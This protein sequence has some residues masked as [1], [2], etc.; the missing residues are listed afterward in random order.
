MFLV[1]LSLLVGCKALDPD[2]T[3]Y[4]FSDCDQMQG[5]MEKMARKEVLWDYH[6]D[7]EGLVMGGM[8]QTDY[9][10]SDVQSEE[11]SA[12]SSYSTTNVQEQGVD[13]ADLVKTDGQYLYSVADDNLVISQAWPVEEVRLLSMTAID[14]RVDGIYLLGDR[15]AVLSRI[16]GTPRPRSGG[17]L[18][19]SL[20]SG[21]TLVT[22]VDVTD[23]SSPVVLRET[24]AE[25]A[26]MESRRIGDRVYVVTT[27]DLDVVGGAETV[28]DARE[29]IR[30]TD[31]TSWLPWRSDLLW[32]G[33]A[34]SE[35]TDT[36]CDCANVWASE[37]EGGTA[38][39]TV[40]SLDLA[41][42]TSGFVGESV[43]GEVATVYASGTSLYIGATET[44]EGPFPTIDDS[45]DTIL[46]RFDISQ[47]TERPSYVASAKVTG[48]LADQFSLSEYNG[49]LRVATTETVSANSAQVHTL[50]EEDG[51]M[52]HLDSLVG[53]AQG[54]DIMSARFLGNMGYVVTYD[55]VEMWDPLFTFDLSDPTDIRMGGELEMSGWSDYL[56]PMEEGW[57]LAVGMDEGSPG[58]QL[59]VS[60]FDVR[61]LDEP[62]LADRELLDAWGSEAQEDHHAFNYFADQA[63]LAIPSWASEGE[64]V[65][66]VL[67][68]RTTGLTPLGRIHQDDVLESFS[69]TADGCSPIRRSVIMDR[70]AYAVSSAG[71]TVATLDDPAIT[72]GYVP[73]LGLD[74]CYDYNWESDDW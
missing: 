12:P 50:Q 32:K 5:Y 9:A 1:L 51:D 53:I 63:A 3:L 59:S 11:G 45:Q 37:R 24:Y 72:L 61:N 15:V 60:L 66:E 48:I 13:E 69:D 14:G 18:A 35:D 73:F 27:Q 55:S 25:G 70:Y 4:A 42:P 41:D 47:G 30:E 54:E 52:V 46:H 22:V 67:D 49:V 28:A 34:W 16:G 38:L 57:L 44:T 56:H 20:H 68:A 29:R 33:N 23:R 19:L 17:D 43:V 6:W 40:M 39:A 71:F 58:W 8:V 64:P 62:L 10:L 65:L 7:P 31:P 2:P 74:P 21:L 26:L 36:V